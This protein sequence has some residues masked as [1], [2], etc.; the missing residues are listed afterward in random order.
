MFIGTNV[1]MGEKMI[2]E[3][4]CSWRLVALPARY[5]ATRRAQ[6]YSANSGADHKASNMGA[7]DISLDKH[8][9]LSKK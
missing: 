6:H 1:L 4:G 5:D 7:P 2:P 9:P 8:R 3:T